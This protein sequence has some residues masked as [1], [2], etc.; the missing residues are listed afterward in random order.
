MDKSRP[1]R[2]A[3][4][5]ESSFQHKGISRNQWQTS[6]QEDRSKQLVFSRIPGSINFIFILAVILRN[7]EIGNIR[8]PSAVGIFRR[9]VHTMKLIKV[10]KYV[11]KP[12]DA[13]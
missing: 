13:F 6:K 12:L 3:N 7:N 1:G 11:I 5:E 2:A 10:I 9:S 4:L 8:C